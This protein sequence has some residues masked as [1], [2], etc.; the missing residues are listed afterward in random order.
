M[1]S[2][3]YPQTKFALD[4]KK[5]H[6]SKEKSCGYY[7]RI[8]FFFSSLIQSLIIVSLVLFMVY[9][10]PEQSS[11]EKR[12]QDLQQSFTQLTAENKQL[13]QLKSNLT[14]LLNTTLTK[15]LKDDQDLHRLRRL[16]NVS[17]ATI[18]N[19]NTKLYM[20]EMEKRN[21][22]PV[23]PAAC[24]GSSNPSTSN[25]LIQLQAMYRLLE[26]NFTQTVQHLSRDLELANRARDSLTL[27]AISLR[28]NSSDLQ[29]Q[30]DA[31]G[32]KCKGDFVQSLDGIQTVTRAFMTRIDGLFPV[33]FPFQLT[34]EK[35][36]EQ[37]DQI[38]SNC[39]S[40]SREVETKFQSYL[41]SVGSQV[42]RIQAESSR[43]NVQNARLQEDLRWS[44]QNHTA[45]AALSRRRSQEAQ[46]RYD[47]ELERLLKEQSKL[48]N[49]NELQKH[50]IAVKSS[51][52]SLLTNQ[53]LNLNQSLRNCIP[54][55]A[56]PKL[57]GL[58]PGSAGTGGTFP[59]LTKPGLGGTGFNFLGLT[60]PGLNVPGIGGT[61]MNS[62]GMNVPGTTS[63]FNIDLQKHLK[64]LQEMANKDSGVSG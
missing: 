13:Q 39:S 50:G 64:E 17:A 49:E 25:R 5:M 45:E 48:R 22:A 31:Y 28:R 7:W 19:F 37:L 21:K 62:Q 4:A 27:E 23:L 55:P 12:A 56:S 57:P 29:R 60:K 42:S 18:L 47:K 11:E 6:K 43:L 41:D 16:A 3:S 10:H 24:P 52:I 20:C 33:V 40:L 38:R 44:R 30:L 32:R 36:K 46:D 54:K 2:G 26:A 59:V 53:V 8:I 14:R 15:K 35:Q 51:E 61:G 1:Y 9:G 63:G 58:L 34:C